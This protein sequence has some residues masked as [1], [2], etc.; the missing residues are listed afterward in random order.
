MLNIYG[1]IYCDL[2]NQSS[3]LTA[4]TYIKSRKGSNLTS[5]LPLIAISSAPYGV[6]RAK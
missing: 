6:T 2:N 4:Y 3:V 1:Y 5:W